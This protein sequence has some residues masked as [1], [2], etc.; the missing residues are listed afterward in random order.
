MVF[1]NYGREEGT[2][3]LNYQSGG[4]TVKMLQRNAKLNVSFLIVLL[5]C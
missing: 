3:I 1:G 4:L 5:N 2:L